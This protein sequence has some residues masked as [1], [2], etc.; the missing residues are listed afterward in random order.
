M[1]SYFKD[2]P[3]VPYRFG[4]NEQPVEFQHL[5]TYLDVIDQV[6]EYKSFYQTY[7]IQNNERPDHASYRL[8]GNSNYY[9]TFYLMN[10]KLRTQGWPVDNSRIYPLAQEYYPNMVVQTSGAVTDTSDLTGAAKPLIQSSTFVVGNWVFFENS[11]QAGKILRIDYDLGLIHI[12]LSNTFPADSV[13]K[14]IPTADGEYIRANGNATDFNTIPTETF[15]QL[16]ISK[17]YKQYD[18]PHHYEDASGER[19][20]PT[21]SS[22]KDAGYPLDLTSVNT[23]QSV[24]YFQRLREENDNLRNISVIK[25]DSIRQI[26]SEFTSLLR[27]IN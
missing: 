15:E 12:D 4:D 19:V 16:N 17:Q 20:Y 1:S 10:D 21:W 18:A 13:I 26:V 22:D 27:G 5:G 6:K 7:N 3:V 24:S 14:T 25:P 2:F 11:E 8:Y 9:W 23:V